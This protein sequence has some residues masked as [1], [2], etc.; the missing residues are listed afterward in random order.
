MQCQAYNQ[1][2][3]DT[4][5]RE[6]TQRKTKDD[7]N[8]ASRYWNSQI[9]YFKYTYHIQREKRLKILA[10]HW[11]MLQ[12]KSSG[13]SENEKVSKLTH[14]EATDQTHPKREL[15]NQKMLNKNNQKQRMKGNRDKTMTRSSAHIYISKKSGEREQSKSSI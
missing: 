12:K 1:K 2:E 5:R 15:V 13:N 14:I 7:R 6:H 11:K 4:Q 9:Q 8:W 3:S 10:E